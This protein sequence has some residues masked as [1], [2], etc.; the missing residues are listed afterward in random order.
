MKI[1]NWRAKKINNT[2]QKVVETVTPQLYL[3]AIS[4]YKQEVVGSLGLKKKSFASG[5]PT[6]PIFRGRA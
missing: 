1:Q 3:R 6:V 4:T 5:N 2:S